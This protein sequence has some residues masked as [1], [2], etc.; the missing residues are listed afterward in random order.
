MSQE[1]EDLDDDEPLELVD[2]V[3]EGLRGLFAEDEEE[4]HREV[5]GV[6]S[7]ALEDE[8]VADNLCD[9]LEAS[10]QH[11]NDD[12]AATLMAAIILGEVRCKRAVPLLVRG[13]SAE[14]DEELRDVSIVALLR[15]GPTALMQ[16]MDA[17]E[18]DDFLALN[19]SAYELLGQTGTLEDP[20]LVQHVADFLETRIGPERRKPLGESAIE[21]LSSA[22]SR[23]GDRRQLGALR[24]VLSEDFHGRNT[25]LQD[26][27][28][29]LEE[30]PSGT[31]YVPT[32]A[33]WEERYGWL[34][35]GGS[36]GDARA[37]ASLQRARGLGSRLEPEEDRSDLDE[38]WSSD[39]EVDEEP[40]DEGEQDDDQ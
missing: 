34:Y 9:L 21:N 26:A 20:R 2:L 18:E 33:P 19:R 3:D 11:R 16:V 36:P 24:R 29:L 25:V 1:P 40:V 6:L 15:M 30:N 39:R 38:D 7:A 27:C 13:L 10:L 4:L 31:A 28:E 23:L 5:R 14:E 17:V 12:S 32:L 37:R 8:E 35:R 22:I